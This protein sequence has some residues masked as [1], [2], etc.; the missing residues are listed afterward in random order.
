MSWRLRTDPE[1]R[2]LKE[3]ATCF[4]LGLVVAVALGWG[5]RGVLAAEQRVLRA[6]ADSL[7]VQ[8]R[9]T[10]ARFDSLAAAAR[11]AAPPH[12]DAARAVDSARV[13]LRRSIA[14]AR[15]ALQQD[16]VAMAR[17][18][19]DLARRAEEQMRLQAIE[20]QAA[21]ERIRRLEV[22]VTYAP[23]VMRDA[24]ALITVQGE[25]LAAARAERSPGRRVLRAVCY[26]AP[27]AGA[28]ALG[29]VI[30]N[31]GGAA[32]GGVSGLAAASLACK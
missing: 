9:E 2:A 27:V 15:A 26:V 5:G 18:L 13:E 23:V 7:R 19:E 1:R 17:A 31:V 22:T 14:T 16:S 8:L 20:R 30:G 6:R 32:V 28:A 24:R 4:V 3:W 11:A 29:A 12:E 10:E 25:A 21:T